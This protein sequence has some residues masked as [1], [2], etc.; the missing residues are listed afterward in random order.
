MKAREFYG[1]PVELRL[2]IIDLGINFTNAARRANI[3]IDTL[4]DA[5]SGKKNLGRDAAQKLR[6]AFGNVIREVTT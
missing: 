3:E 1:N 5:L 6:A 4:Y 2:K